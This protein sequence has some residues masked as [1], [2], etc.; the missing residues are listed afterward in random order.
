MKLPVSMLRCVLT[1]LYGSALIAASPAFA[2]ELRQVGSIAIDGKPMTNFDIGFI[3]P[4][5]DRYYFSDRSN[6]AIEVIDTKTDR[7]VSRIGGFV[8]AVLK[9]GGKVNTHVSG[10]D[11]VL[12]ADGAL[13]AGDGDSTIKV[14]DPVPARESP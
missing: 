7:V 2:S 13:W 4:A 8:G 5:S 14:F 1:T 6:A 3:D 11:G 9:E 10:P 12:V